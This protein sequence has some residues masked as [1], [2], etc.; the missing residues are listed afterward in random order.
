M[1]K[2]L[3]RAATANEKQIAK[4]VIRMSHPNRGQDKGFT[5]TQRQ[6]ENDS[7]AYTVNCYHA[8]IKRKGKVADGSVVKEDSSEGF[9]VVK[10]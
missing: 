10:W 3:T 8:H 9:V 5:G 6:F 4:A 2:E 1:A 7:G